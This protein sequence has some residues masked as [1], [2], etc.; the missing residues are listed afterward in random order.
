VVDLPLLPL[1]ASSGALWDGQI[2]IRGSR[3]ARTFTI[4]LQELAG[5]Q[6]LPGAAGLPCC[7]G[8]LRFLFRRRGFSSIGRELKPAPKRVTRLPTP[9]FTGIAMLFC[10]A[11]LRHGLPMPSDGG[12]S[13]H[14][15]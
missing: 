6:E 1:L 7:H 11:R 13:R 15:A 9:R 8:G 3:F 12:D 2:R 14:V 4:L 5:R 10:T